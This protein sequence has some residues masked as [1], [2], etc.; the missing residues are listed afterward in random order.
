MEIIIHGTVA[1][2]QNIPLLNMH[3][4]HGVENLAT[5]YG[6]LG[7]HIHLNKPA[8]TYRSKIE[9]YTNVNNYLYKL[10][11]ATLNWNTY[12][13]HI[14]SGEASIKYYRPTITPLSTIWLAG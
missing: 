5:V 14:V 1:T 9:Q 3:F 2:L 8:N 6:L 7:A 12:I 11:A 13:I 4:A 10:V